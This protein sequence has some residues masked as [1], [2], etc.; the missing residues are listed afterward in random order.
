MKYLRTSFYI[1]FI[2]VVGP[3]ATRAQESVGSPYG[4]T[5]P[6]LP[7]AAS[8]PLGVWQAMQPVDRQTVSDFVEPLSTTSV[9][10]ELKVGQ[11][12]LVSLKKPMATVRSAGVVAIGDPTVL[13]FDLLPNPRLIRLTGR[14]AGATDLTILTADDELITFDVVINYDLDLLRAQVSKRFPDCSIQIH[15]MRE[16]LILEGQVR[17]SDQVVQVEQMAQAFIASMQPRQRN[18]QQQQGNLPGGSPTG[19]DGEAARQG[20][21]ND[22]PDDDGVAAQELGGRPTTNVEFVA[23]TVIN[24]L[25]L[26]GVEQIMLQVRVAELNRTGLRQIGTDWLVG[27]AKGALTGT[28]IGGSTVTAGA[29]GGLGGLIGNG[30]TELGS[31]GTAF[32]IFPS[33]DVN[34]MVAALR[35]NSLLNILAEPNLVAMNGHEANFLAGG[36]FPVPI[37]QGAL[38]QITVEYKDFGVQLQ[39]VPHI[40]DEQTVRLQVAPEVSTI[41]NTLGTTLVTGGA[42]IPGINTRRVSTTVEMREGETLALAG[43]LQVTM[44]ARTSRIP[45][46]GDLPYL[47]PFFS[48]TSHERVEKELL[49]L[50]TPVMVSP[51]PAG[52]CIPYPGMDLAEPND[53]EFYLLSRLEGRTGK[54]HRSTT[55]WDD[56]LRCIDRMRL[57]QRYIQGSVGLAR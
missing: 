3:S 10:I 47:G 49:V 44:D 45:G 57:E 31:R 27:S 22:D 50:V 8:R 26:P 52:E 17:R 32:G 35:Q 15:Q 28:Q 12:R 42:P 6:V 40:I 53:L 16:H 14:R 2:A 38:G 54:P 19:R 56:P 24:L 23:G 34:L 4:R 7:E 30:T 13:D 20:Q 46:L 9:V 39:F 41:D 1:A 43:L 5:K 33:A 21:R 37:P 18:Q 55:T 36:Q 51:I 29:L 25:R 11:G 48:N